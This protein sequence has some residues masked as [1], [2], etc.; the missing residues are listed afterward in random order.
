[1]E[2]HLDAVEQGI[3]LST[4]PLHLPAYLLLEPTVAFL[5]LCSFL[6]LLEHKL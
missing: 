1:M 3:Q 6:G 4:L 2:I 5:C